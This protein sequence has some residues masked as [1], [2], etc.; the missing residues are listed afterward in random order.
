MPR[1]ALH[2][3]V[4]LASIISAVSSAGDAQLGAPTFQPTPQSTVGWRGD[5][6]GRYPGATPPINWERKQDGKGYTTKGI[7]WMTPLPNI[8]VSTPIVV[9]P[10]IFLTTEMADL[11]CLDKQTGRILWIRSNLEF[12]GLS[13]EELKA[14]PQYAE[15]LLPLVAQIAKVNA[16]LVEAMNAQAP[17]A[18]SAAPAQ[19]NAPAL[20]KKKDLEKQVQDAQKLIDKKKFEHNWAQ[21]VFGYAGP[22]PTSD[23]KHVCAFF[24]TGITCCYDLDGNRKWIHYGKGDG[25]EHGNFASP[26]LC[27]NKVAVWA[28]EIRA[29]DVDSGKLEWTVP[30]KSFNTYGSLFRVISGNELVAAFQ[31]GF[32]VRIR[33]GAPIWDK[34]VFGDCVAT[35]IVENGYIFSHI[36]Y[37]KNG[38][39]KDLFS[40]FKIPA[41]TDSGK[42]TSTH[43]FK[44]D[45]G[46]DLAAPEDK[47][48]P[49][50]RGYVASPL[51]VDGLIYQITEGSGLMVNDAASGEQVYRKVLPMHAKTE[52]WNWA[53]TSASPT[54]AGKNI[55]LMDN[56]G[57]T[58]VLQPGRQYKELAQNMLQESRDGKS[59]TQ[60]VSTPI[61]DASR[62]YY[63][64]PGFLYC[65]GDK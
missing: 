57:T 39:K 53:G 47:K 38:N 55:Y 13:D 11:V 21:A 29:Y 4:L 63:R 59:Q 6:T 24:T 35:P 9:G 25:S 5:G 33:D 43:M 22:T 50:D 40:A 17:K 56:Q 42:L 28:Q 16:E 7:L 51:L 54:L 26:L 10:R 27:G 61:F 64:T 19:Q 1:I 20:K 60:F 34:G 23:G 45:W 14:E 30:A 8:G 65:I 3:I 12:E 52:Y 46:D 2:Q 58:I 36:G 37:P 18:M 15:K 48:A 31:W 41:S 32:F 44:L 62:M 49:F